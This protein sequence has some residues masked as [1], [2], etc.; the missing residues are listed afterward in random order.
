MH[1]VFMKKVPVLVSEI[2]VNDN[3]DHTVY[4]L[5]RILA[6]PSDKLTVTSTDNKAVSE[7]M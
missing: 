6:P 4:Y 2:S 1:G 3:H 7:A 5:G